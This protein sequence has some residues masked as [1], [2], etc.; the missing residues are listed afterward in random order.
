MLPIYGQLIVEKN[1]AFCAKTTTTSDIAL[2]AQVLF[3][4]EYLVE[5]NLTNQELLNTSRISYYQHEPD[6]KLLGQSSTN[7]INDSTDILKLNKQ[8]VRNLNKD[9][10]PFLD[11]HIFEKEDTK[12][13]IVVA[14]YILK[15]FFNLNL[16]IIY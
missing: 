11:L 3:V 15:I 8:Y 13:P 5:V 16:K 6:P 7:A 2:N 1:P 12:K 9:F 10:N 4:Q 14:L